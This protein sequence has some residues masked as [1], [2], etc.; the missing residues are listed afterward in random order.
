MKIEE[1][2][3][4]KTRAREGAEEKRTA[5]KNKASHFRDVSPSGLMDKASASEAGDCGFK[6]HQGHNYGWHH[7]AKNQQLKGRLNSI[8]GRGLSIGEVLNTVKYHLSGSELSRLPPKP[9][10]MT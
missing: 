5:K 4:M 3:R 10:S 7:S 2:R 6:S 8:K 1:R 9:R